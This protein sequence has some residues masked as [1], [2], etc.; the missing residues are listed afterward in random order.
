MGIYSVGLIRF[1]LLH[2]DI[3]KSCANF[4]HQMRV[5]VKDLDYKTRLKAF[6]SYTNVYKYIVA[7]FVMW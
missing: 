3:E 5:D 6:V 1:V 4:C 7:I 2:E